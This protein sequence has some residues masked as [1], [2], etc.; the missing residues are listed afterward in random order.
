MTRNE[1]SAEDLTVTRALT[2]VSSLPDGADSDAQADAIG[3]VYVSD[4]EPGIARLRCGQGFTFRS[5][6]GDTL[7]RDDPDR[8]RAEELA[9]PPAWTDVWVCRDA[10]GHIQA[11]G[12]D[13]AGRKQYLYH[14]RWRRIRE[15]TKFHRL[16]AFAAA[17][18]RVR[19]AVDT[20]LRARRFSHDKV[21]ALV[22]ALLDQTL[23]RVGND[24]YAD[25]NGT[26]GVTTLH[27]DHVEVEGNWVRF[28][29][30]GKSGQEREL[31]LRHPRLAR[32]LLRCEEIPGQRMFSYQDEDG[33]HQVCSATVN[34]YLTDVAGDEFT[35]KDFRTWG[36][37]VVVAEHLHDT[38]PADSARDQ[39]RAVLGAVDAA[40]ERLGN[41]RAVA[42]SSYVDPRVPKA[43]RLG[44]LDDTWDDHDGVEDRLSPA[45]RAVQRVLDLDLPPT[46]RPT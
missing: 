31:E 20:R 30:V 41:T 21:L 18:P 36:A 12:R 5:P 1:G 22:L 26:Y 34:S 11:T 24:H 3:L 32:Q 15:A 29:F 38:G 4:D 14:P 23:I 10:R 37:T 39:D 7:A 2:V 40:A 16:G 46:P 35:A 43:Y 6:D 42:R 27:H 28:S 17:L 45:E 33:W 8:R 19:D 13:D 25:L 44:V 9:I